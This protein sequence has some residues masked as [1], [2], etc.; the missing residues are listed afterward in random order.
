MGV[1]LRYYQTD[2][3]GKI[4]Y[5]LTMAGNDLVVL[6]TGAG[7]SIVIAETANMLQQDVLILQPTAEILEQNA[8][9]LRLYVDPSEVGVYS[10][11][12]GEKEIKKYT[13]AMIGSIH[14][15]PELFAHFKI[16][17]MDEAHDYNIK[18][19]SSMLTSFLRAIGNPKVIGFTAT[20]YRNMSAYHKIEGTE[21]LEVFVTLKLIN[22]VVD[23][24]HKKFWDRIIYNI[25]N[26]ELT[27]KGYLSPLKYI[28]ASEIDQRSL[29]L[30]ASRTDFDLDKFTTLQ[31]GT[32]ER[33]IAGIEWG[34][35]T[36]KSVLVFCPSVAQAQS[37][38]EHFPASAYVTGKTPKKERRQILEDFKAGRIQT[39]FNVG[40]LTTGFDHPA[41]DCIVLNRPTRS[42]G[43]YYQMLGRGVRK[44]EGKNHCMVIDFTGTVK[45]LGRVHTIKLRKPLKLWEL[46][47]ETGQW[48]GSALY[49]YKISADRVKV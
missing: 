25:D 14:R 16:V 27:Q 48:H 19:V 49:N 24:K 2:S 1:D 43:L 26:E 34:Q 42:V 30:N 11:S 31:R 13:F 36:Y 4:K 17:L 10:A 46:W 22:R 38:S 3:L 39:V 23:K 37:L 20:P 18:A 40:V 29:P 7:K 41:L 45:A 15:H 9:K 5:F 8:A 6:P 21:D 28:H 12:C 32:R 33:V 47:T 44:A 35:K